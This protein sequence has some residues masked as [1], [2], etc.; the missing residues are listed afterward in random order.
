MSVP[1]SSGKKLVFNYIHGPN[2]WEK[3]VEHGL[4]K[5]QKDLAATVKDDLSLIISD[6]I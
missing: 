3:S 5:G 1:A 6:N 4:Y 2:P